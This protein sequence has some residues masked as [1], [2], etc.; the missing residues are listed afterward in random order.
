MKRFM[1]SLISKT[2]ASGRSKL[3]VFSGVDSAPTTAAQL[4]AILCQ[5][6]SATENKDNNNVDVVASSE[7]NSE[8]ITTSTSSMFSMPKYTSQLTTKTMGRTVL[9]SPVLHSTQ[10]VMQSV[11]NKIPRG[12]VCVADQQT[13]G[14]G[15][16]KNVWYSPPG[17]LLFSFTFATSDGQN[18]P[19]AQYLMSLALVKAVHRLSGCQDLPVKIKW[20]NDIYA[21]DVEVKEKEQVSS[22]N[23]T[24]DKAAKPR[25]PSTSSSTLDYSS[26]TSP[27]K[28][29]NYTKIGGVLCQSS[30]D[31]SSKSF[32]VVAGVG[33]NVSNSAPTTCLQSL[34]TATDDTTTATATATAVN[35]EL[36]LSHFFNELEPMLER[37]N[38]SGFDT[39]YDDYIQEWLH[40]GQKIM[41][42]D[43][44]ERRKQGEAFVQGVDGSGGGGGGGSSDGVHGNLDQTEVT[45]IGV[46]ESSGLLAIDGK[47]QKYELLP[48][49]NSF[50]FMDGLI[51]R[52]I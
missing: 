12:T 32:V 44:I 27:P 2:S 14:R 13:A 8:Q 11:C 34:H 9:Y 24:G 39:F 47:G 37:F 29:G 33:L 19:F 36:V 43:L 20:P 1:S 3:H 40:T 30:Y 31:Y 50:N 17:C 28:H 16:G 51:K 5:E 10:T 21:A 49:G 42:C 35:R 46:A 38:V 48:D 45:I 6:L 18:L 26:F 7:L 25:K 22:T 41:V 15:R 4:S 52:K 23:S